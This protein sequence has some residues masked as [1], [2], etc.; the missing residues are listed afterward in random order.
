MFRECAEQPECSLIRRETAA[1]GV[2][3]VVPPAG[4]YRGSKG[5]FVLGILWS[6]VVS[7]AGMIVVGF[8]QQAGVYNKWALLGLGGLAGVGV[9]MLAA[10]IQMGRRQAA[11]AVVGGKLLF[12][13]TGPFGTLQ[14]E[15]P[16]AQV[17]DIFTGPSGLTSG[18]PV[19]E[20]Q[21]LPQSELKPIGLLAGRDEEELRWLATELRRAVGC[22]ETK[23]E[24]PNAPISGPSADA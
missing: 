7:V 18:A 5:L 19:I 14:R 11:F 13:Q 1:D 3:L 17:Q 22:R 16:C 2:T 8:M 21:I 4:L 9:W 24:R 15:W 23:P 10:G 20:L 6:A 12:L